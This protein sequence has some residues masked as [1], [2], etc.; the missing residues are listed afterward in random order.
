MSSPTLSV[1]ELLVP[2]LSFQQKR[3]D[4]AERA[5]ERERV[6]TDQQERFDQESSRL[7]RQEE[8]DEKHR[9]DLLDL[10]IEDR[11]FSRQAHD[12]ALSF[13]RETLKQETARFEAERRDAA[14]RLAE[15]GKRHEETLK[16]LRSRVVSGDTDLDALRKTLGE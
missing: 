14:R 1:W 7:D 9:R 5:A 4:A 10:Q 16:V 6:W 11:A 3:K 15:D 12:D 8:R 13:Q 2:L